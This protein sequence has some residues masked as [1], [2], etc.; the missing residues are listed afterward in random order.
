MLSK[1]KKGYEGIKIAKKKHAHA[2]VCN[3]YLKFAQHSHE[4]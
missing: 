1:R 4:Y 2:W 3:F